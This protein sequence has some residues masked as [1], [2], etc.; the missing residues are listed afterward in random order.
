MKQGGGLGGPEE[1]SAL[2]FLVGSS[3]G[4]QDRF[5]IFEVKRAP[6]YEVSSMLGQVCMAFKND[7]NKRRDFGGLQFCTRIIWDISI[8]LIPHQKMFTTSEEI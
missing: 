6:S 1:G 2:R 8:E 4:Y 3:G 7:E 5:V